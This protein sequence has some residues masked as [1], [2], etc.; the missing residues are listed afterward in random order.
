MQRLRRY[1]IGL[2]PL[3][4]I[5]LSAACR[6]KCR[7]PEFRGGGKTALRRIRPIPPPTSPG[8]Q[9]KGR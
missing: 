4:G 8:K 5:V 9:V 3:S 2:G 7:I 6:D 1:R